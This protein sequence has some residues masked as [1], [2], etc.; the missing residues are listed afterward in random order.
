[1]SWNPVLNL[2]LDIKNKIPKEKLWEY[3]SGSCLKYWAGLLNDPYYNEILKPLKIRISLFPAD[4]HGRLCPGQDRSRNRDVRAGPRRIN[5]SI[6][7]RKE[8]RLLC[9]CRWG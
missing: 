2:F 8:C 4:G 6:R 1:M 7:C 5:G 3:E 9:P